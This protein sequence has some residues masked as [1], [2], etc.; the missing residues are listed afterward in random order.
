MVERTVLQLR[1]V[2]AQAHSRIRG[3]APDRQSDWG[4]TK[5]GQGLTEGAVM[6]IGMFYYPPTA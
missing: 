1:L 2:Q 4:F 6:A 5:P 3:P